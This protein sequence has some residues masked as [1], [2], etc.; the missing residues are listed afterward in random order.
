M[1]VASITLFLSSLPY[2][3]V[4]DPQGENPGEMV[5]VWAYVQLYVSLEN[6]FTF[7]VKKADI[8]NLIQLVFTVLTVAMQDD[9]A[10]KLFFET[11]VSCTCSSM[12]MYNT[13]YMTA[14]TCM[15]I[16]ILHS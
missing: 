13:L 2:M 14:C 12:Y 4:S 15:Y 16:Q 6:L 8:L 10:N 11:N 5:S 7:L 9:P 1:G 3:A